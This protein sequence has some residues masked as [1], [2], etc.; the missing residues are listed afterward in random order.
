MIKL[1]NCLFFQAEFNGENKNL[2][3]LI[4]ICKNP[5][6]PHFLGVK[7]PI[8]LPSHDPIGL[9][10]ELVQVITT[11]HVCTNVH[12]DRTIFATAI[13]LTDKYIDIYIV[14]S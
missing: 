7:S 11:L 5:E 4:L 2:I 12:K 14:T 1:V 6:K 10:F 9:V 13:V 8:T 3:N